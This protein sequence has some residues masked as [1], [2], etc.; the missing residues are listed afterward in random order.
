MSVAMTTRWK[1]PFKIL[2]VTNNGIIKPRLASSLGCSSEFDK[3]NGTHLGFRNEPRPDWQ[4]DLNRANSSWMAMAIAISSVEPSLFHGIE[5]KDPAVSG[6]MSL[7]EFLWKT[8][9]YRGYRPFVDYIKYIKNLALSRALESEIAPVDAPSGFKVPKHIAGFT[10]ARGRLASKLSIGPETTSGECAHHY[11]QFYLIGKALAVP[12]T[13]KIRGALEKHRTDYSRVWSLTPEL[14]KLACEWSKEWITSCLAKAKSEP[15]VISTHFGPASSISS[16][17]GD[18][19]KDADAAHV[20]GPYKAGHSPLPTV[21]ECDMYSVFGEKKIDAEVLLSL[22]IDDGSR[23]FPHRFYYL[24]KKDVDDGLIND[25]YLARD[26]ALSRL[27]RAGFVPPGTVSGLIGSDS[28]LGVFFKEENYDHIEVESYKGKTRPVEL[29]CVLERGDKARVVNISEWEVTVLSQFVR[30]YLYRITSSDD[31]IPAL[32]GRSPAAGFLSKIR[33]DIQRRFTVKSDEFLSQE[34]QEVLD[35]LELLSLDLSRCSDLILASL[36]DGFLEGALQASPAIND[37]FLRR[38]WHICQSQRD[39]VYRDHPDIKLNGPDNRA[40]AMGDPPTWWIDNAYTKFASMLAMKLVDLGLHPVP[41]KS[42]TS[43]ELEIAIASMTTEQRKFDF[44]SPTLACRSGDDEIRLATPEHNKAIASIYSS[45]GG[46]VSE[47][48]N[49]RSRRFGVF[50]ENHIERAGT[51]TPWNI[52]S[53]LDLLRIKSL[54]PPEARRPGESAMP[55]FWTRGSAA[56]SAIAWWPDDSMESV[57]TRKVIA[58][59]NFVEIEHA[60][61]LGLQVFAPQSLG[62]L[63]YPSEKGAAWNRANKLTRRLWQLLASAHTVRADWSP[64]NVTRATDLASTFSTSI[65]TNPYAESDRESLEETFQALE[66]QGGILSLA[67]LAEYGGTSTEEFPACKWRDYATPFNV[68]GGNPKRTRKMLRISGAA[69]IAR[70]RLILNRGMDTFQYG[71]SKRQTNE[72]A[73]A[74]YYKTRFD[75]SELL[76]EVMSN[77]DFDVESLSGD[78]CIH[79]AVREAEYQSLCF[80]VDIDQLNE[81]IPDLVKRLAVG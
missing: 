13:D 78:L 61:K 17:R 10:W 43:A 63:S 47:G 35:A 41:D 6:V 46:L 22:P 49:I 79:L 38:V 80:F 48:T 62:G 23:A 16:T 19:G 66:A 12:G 3:S 28:Y 18:G 29:T 70:T 8:F 71:A 27:A 73:A 72:R 24:S 2:A 32:S 15:V 65:H 74:L 26:L 20:L 50:C 58:F 37:P 76:E 45:I 9:V 36:A 34:E 59:E 56:T 81:R 52:L 51:T 67:E 55:I 40:P 69:S 31:E 7:I 5:V 44:K 75:L 54:I 33:W 42:L 68:E 21:I 60:Y 14:D 57:L 39:L 25:Q 4:L 1:I 30:S 77:F 11:F 53:W 64:P